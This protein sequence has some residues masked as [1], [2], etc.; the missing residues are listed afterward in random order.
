VSTYLAELTFRIWAIELAVSGVNYF[1]VMKRIY[2]PRVGEL[3]AHQIGMSTRIVYRFVFAYILL[4]RMA[5][6]RA[7]PSSL[8]RSSGARSVLAGDIRAASHPRDKR[9][10]TLP[11][12]RWPPSRQRR[13]TYRRHPCP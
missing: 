5:T 8:G 11:G 10:R 4:A 1:V 12:S 6:R 2:E 13:S 3:H 7:K 9:L